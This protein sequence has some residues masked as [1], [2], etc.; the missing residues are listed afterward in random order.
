MSGRFTRE[1]G[2]ALAAL[3]GRNALAALTSPPPAAGPDG[4]VSA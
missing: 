3:A 2:A 4:A 1:E